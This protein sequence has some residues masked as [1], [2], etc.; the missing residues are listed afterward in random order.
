M[1]SRVCASSAPN[2]SSSRST[3][4][5]VASARTMPT[6]C[7]IPPESRSGYWSSKASSPAEREQGARHALALVRAD[8]LHLQPELDVL[9]HRLPGKQRVL[10]EHHAAIGAGARDGLAIHPHPPAARRTEARDGVQQRGFAA[11]R[12]ADDGNELARPDRERDVGH[13][14]DHVP[15]GL[16]VQAEPF[17]LDMSLGPFHGAGAAHGCAIH[18]IAARPPARI[19]TL[20]TRPSSPIATM[21][22]TMSEYWISE[23]ASQVK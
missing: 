8:S 18:G 23:Y 15:V 3:L 10:L 11:A 22:S 5:P 17:D 4:G 2:G 21:P 1:I 12:G 14:F 9:A 19:A 6:R 7:F 16:V 20:E 13:R